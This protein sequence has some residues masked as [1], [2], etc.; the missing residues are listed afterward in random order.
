MRRREEQQARRAGLTEMRQVLKRQPGRSQ[1]SVEPVAERTLP[2]E[3]V[4]AG[5]ERRQ[6]LVHERPAQADNRLE[7]AAP[8]LL[9]RIGRQGRHAAQRQERG[10]AASGS[11][12]ETEHFPD[13]RAECVGRRVRKRPVELTRR[14]S[15]S[16]RAFKRVGPSFSSGMTWPR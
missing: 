14:G 4:R 7:P 11:G 8:E 2:P 6:P 15:R 3:H 16:A 12:L 13:I 1:R 9:H 5:L 10:V